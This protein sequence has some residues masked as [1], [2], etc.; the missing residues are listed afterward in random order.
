MT[1][2]GSSGKPA[3]QVFSTDRPVYYWSYPQPRQCK[4]I[5]ALNIKDWRTMQLAEQ[6]K[7]NFAKNL[8]KLRTE[9]KLTQAGL[10]DELNARYHLNLKRASVANY[11]AQEA[12]PKIDTL[13]CIADY[14]RKTI[15]QVISD[16]VEKTVLN[17][18]RMLREHRPAIDKGPAQED[19]TIPERYMPQEKSNLKPENLPDIN[20]FFQEYIDAVANR[21]FYVELFK[22]LLKEF[23]DNISQLKGP[24]QV[25]HL[26]NKTYLGCLISKS[27]FFQDQLETVLK[28]REYEV[29]RGFQEGSS[30]RMLATA[31]QMPEEEV[32][33]TFQSAKNKVISAIE[34]F[35][36]E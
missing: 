22:K 26:F 16:N 20:V 7:R 3:T 31:L 34:N 27:K 9:N 18:P 13:Y 11:E 1:S 14:F 15:D 32:L 29:F 17:Y 30:L 10:V 24:D 12:M 6:L 36:S 4:F 25:T 8:A 35:Q 19:Q 28:G 21:Q 33:A 5:R 2:E 23:R